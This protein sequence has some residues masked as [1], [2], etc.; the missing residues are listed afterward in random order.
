M[1]FKLV[2]QYG[3]A[4]LQM[5]RRSVTD[6]SGFE[7]AYEHAKS[8]QLLMY[9]VDTSYNQN[10]YQPGVKSGSR[11]L[12]PTFYALF[13]ASVGLYNQAYQATLDTRAV[14]MPYTWSSDVPQ[15]A[16]LPVLRKGKMGNVSPSN[17]VIRW[18]A[19]GE[20]LLMMEQICTLKSFT[21]DFGI[22]DAPKLIRLEMTADGQRWEE[23]PL[24]HANGKTLYKAD[25]EGRN[26]HKIRLT[27]MTGQEQKVYFKQF[28]FEEK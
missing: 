6:K 17:E 15:L 12:L 28:G 16:A 19:G 9:K 8:L 11:I 26:V 2:G 13:K 27:N 22:V 23:I 3:E 25:V 14:Y 20:A 4:V 10:P 18:Q 5:M 7:T 21:V 24:Q 1:Q